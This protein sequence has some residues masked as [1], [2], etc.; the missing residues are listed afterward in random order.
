MRLTKVDTKTLAAA[1]LSSAPKFLAIITTFA[2]AGIETITM[3]VE[4][5]TGSNLPGRSLFN[6]EKIARMIAG[7]MISLYKVST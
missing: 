2:I 1:S 3:S 4:T 6:S 5:T 7:P